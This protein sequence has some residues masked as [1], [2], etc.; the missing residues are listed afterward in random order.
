MLMR[1][2]RL[3][4]RIPCIIRISIFGAVLA[5]KTCILYTAKYGNCFTMENKAS[6]KDCFVEGND[7]EFIIWFRDT[8]VESTH[9]YQIN[10]IPIIHIGMYL[11]PIESAKFLSLSETAISA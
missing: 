6:F 4:Q 9:P 3:K 5:E 10:M 11:A 2:A 7:F 8:F 1:D